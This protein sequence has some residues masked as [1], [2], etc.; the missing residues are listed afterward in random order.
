MYKDIL[1][2]VPV[3]C[4]YNYWLCNFSEELNYI[5]MLIYELCKDKKDALNQ[6]LKI[7]NLIISSMMMVVQ[8]FESICKNIEKQMGVVL[9]R[10]IDDLFGKMIL[11]NLN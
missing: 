10:I 5:V 2:F 8:L 9:F 1:D 4:K 7:C 11:Q 3:R 6:T